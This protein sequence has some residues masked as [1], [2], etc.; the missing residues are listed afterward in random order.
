VNFPPGDLVCK[1]L[2]YKDS[3]KMKKVQKVACFWLETVCKNCNTGFI[4][5]F[6]K[7][8]QYASYFTL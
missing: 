1:V 2:K 8:S 7:W 4:G 6:Y 5:N 3:Q